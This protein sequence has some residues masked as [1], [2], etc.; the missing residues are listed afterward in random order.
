VTSYLLT[1][2]QL[3]R[4]R[5]DLLKLLPGTAIIQAATAAPDGG[6]GFSESWTPVISGTVP[7]RVD[8]LNMTSQIETAGKAEGIIISYAVTL[9]YDAPAVPGNR[10]IIGGQTYDIRRIADE[11][12]WPISRLCIVA[13]V[14]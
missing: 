12:S 10:L 8:R 13:R 7:C 2:D 1:S 3:A 11:V 14:Q 4:M 5:A 6:G 9:P